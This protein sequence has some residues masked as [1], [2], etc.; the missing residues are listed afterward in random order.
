MDNLEEMDKFLEMYKLP[1]LN[2]EK[3]ESI[4]RPT[5]S[6][7]MESIIN[8][9]KQLPTNKSLGPDGFTGEFCQTFKEELTPTVIKLFQKLKRKEHFQNHSTRPRSP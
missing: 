5:T 3:I 8:N 1:R 4:N 2:Q 7:E 6:N 9:K